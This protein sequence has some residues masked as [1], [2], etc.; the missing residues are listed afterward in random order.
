MSLQQGRSSRILQ[1]FRLPPAPFDF[2]FE[3]SSHQSF[4]GRALR[5]YLETRRRVQ[6]H[7]Q[8][9]FGAAKSHSPDNGASCP[10]LG[11]G[12]VKFPLKFW[13]LRSRRERISG[14]YMLAR[15]GDARRSIRA[16]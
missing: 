7:W 5:E 1:D 15:P 11:K 12:F 16:R 8:I 13:R 6:Q 4:W 2:K 3:A 10:K 14:K 9:Q